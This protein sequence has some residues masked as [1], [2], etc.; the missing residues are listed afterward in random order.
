MSETAPAGHEADLSSV[1]RQ[2]SADSFVT[3]TDTIRHTG[4]TTVN[5]GGQKNEPPNT[6]A[7]CSTQN[8]PHLDR[9][10]YKVE[11]IHGPSNMTV[12]ETEGKSHEA[13]YSAKK[14]DNTTALFEAVDVN[15]TNEN[16]GDWSKAKPPTIFAK[17]RPYIK[18]FSTR[19][20]SA[21]YYVVQYYPAQD[22][23]SDQMRIEWPYMVIWHHEQ[24]LEE[25]AAIFQSNEPTDGESKGLCGNE[26]VSHEIACLL[27]FVRG[28]NGDAVRKARERWAAG[29][30][31]TDTLW[32]FYKPG[33]DVYCD[34]NRRGAWETY[35]VASV[36]TEGWGR[37]ERGLTIL[38][39][40]LQSE[41]DGSFL[42][43]KNRYLSLDYSQTLT[44]ISE[45]PLIPCEFAETNEDVRIMG[46]R[47]KEIRA[48]FEERGEM[49]CHLRHKQCFG[50]DG[51]TR[52]HPI[53]PYVGQVMVDG[54]QWAA[55]RTSK[56]PC[57][58]L[59]TA[60]LHEIP[61]YRIC[62][63]PKCTSKLSDGAKTAKF[64]NYLGDIKD[65]TS[66]MKFLC[67]GT[68]A[69]F[70]FKTRDWAELDVL[71]FRKPFFDGDILKRLVIPQET[72]A[73]IT[74]LTKKYVRKL[75][76]KSEEEDIKQELG[77][78]I[79]FVGK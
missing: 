47:G 63:C 55:D 42:Y 78:I 19:L 56:E 76:A 23:R 26:G 13:L 69:A 6:E 8:A 68:I 21:L 32:L 62:T 15:I 17:D 22:F 59:E 64:L 52:T 72:K 73:L 33:A 40:K 35:V 60:H 58:V 66:H 31:P 71:S 54:Q 25:Y 30:V 27:D 77:P 5:A 65:A 50:Y 53:R 36:S 38:A 2:Q 29:C 48:F 20:I 24:A 49:Y 7:P 74:S 43:S 67:Q 51:L 14:I 70:L 11:Y 79:G 34:E 45:L 4:Q 61:S 39:W 12:F 3:N 41:V 10:A 37:F 16:K 75:I 44:N 1:E 28:Q 46:R 9:I 57:G 18:I